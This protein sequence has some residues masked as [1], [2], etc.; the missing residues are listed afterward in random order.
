MSDTNLW[1]IAKAYLGSATFFTIA[2]E[3]VMFIADR[4]GFVTE[5]DYLLPAIGAFSIPALPFGIH[6]AAR[7]AQLTRPPQKGPRFAPA[8][9]F[10]WVVKPPKAIIHSWG[11]EDTEQPTKTVTIGREPSRVEFV[12]YEDGMRSQ[13]SESRLYQFC[14]IAW[15]RQQAVHFGSLA[16]NRVLSREHFTK[17]ARPRFPMPDYQSCVHILDS[18]ALI[19]NR[20]KGGELFYPPGI[21]VEEAINR[22]QDRPP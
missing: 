16:S 6:L 5:A 18:R 14:K 17:E 2:G 13:I 12:F 8:G 15:R 22:W 7:V 20:Y 19:I 3:G 21:T 10:G 11:L 1:R 4:Y 9:V